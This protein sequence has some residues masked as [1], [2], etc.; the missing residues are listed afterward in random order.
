[1]VLPYAMPALVDPLI[2]EFVKTPLV[3]ATINSPL[4]SYSNL[5]T[6]FL[7]P[8]L[9]LYSAHDSQSDTFKSK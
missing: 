5:L 9:P 7:P 8:F 3:Q 2:Y 6:A 1:M 4:E